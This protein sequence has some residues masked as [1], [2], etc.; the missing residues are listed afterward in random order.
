[1]LSPLLGISLAQAAGLQARS[2]SVEVGLV[3]K[4]LWVGLKE[5]SSCR[6]RLPKAAGGQNIQSAPLGISLAQASGPQ[7]ISSQ[8]KVG[9]LFKG[10]WV[11][12]EGHSSRRASLT[13]GTQ[14]ESLNGAVF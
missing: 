11:G 13:P 3:L 4:G 14:P 6:A 5:H 2:S 7:A 1:M 10:L 12:S 9:L 8:V